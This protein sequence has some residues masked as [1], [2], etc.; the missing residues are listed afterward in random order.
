[1]DN[2]TSRIAEENWRIVEAKRKAARAKLYPEY[3][4]YCLKKW[5]EEF[6]YSQGRAA[7]YELYHRERRRVL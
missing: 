2:K 6:E 5:G 4:D 7:Q 3:V 1:M